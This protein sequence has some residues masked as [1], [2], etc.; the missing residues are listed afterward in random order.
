MDPEE[1]FSIQNG[2]TSFIIN[3]MKGS[4]FIPEKKKTLKIPTKRL[5]EVVSP[6]QGDNLALLKNELSCVP[7]A[8][9]ANKR[10]PVRTGTNL[11]GTLHGM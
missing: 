1:S 5:R 2:G 8:L 10:L 11:N 4:E 6:N 7:P 9:S 3:N